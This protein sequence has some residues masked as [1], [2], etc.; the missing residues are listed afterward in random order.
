MNTRTNCTRRSL[1]AL[2]IGG[3][4]TLATALPSRAVVLPDPIGRDSSS[5]VREVPRYFDDNAL[6][7]VQIGLGALGGLALAG[8]GAAVMRTRRHHPQL[9]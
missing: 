1:A 3:I 9:V 8:A 6:E 4:I 2:A 7:V 5:H